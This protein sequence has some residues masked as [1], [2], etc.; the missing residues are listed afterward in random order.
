MVIRPILI[1][2]YQLHMRAAKEHTD[3]IKSISSEPSLLAFTYTQ[4]KQ[5]L[6]MQVKADI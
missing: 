1:Q 5:S 4:Q 2:S 3:I 6:M